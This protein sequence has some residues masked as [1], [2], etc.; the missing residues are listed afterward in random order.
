MHCTSVP[1]V[2]TEVWTVDTKVEILFESCEALCGGKTQIS[3]P[4]FK[5]FSLKSTADPDHFEV[6]VSVPV[7][8]LD[9]QLQ[10]V[11]ESFHTT[12]APTRY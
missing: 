11:I 6:T 10:L 2:T 4:Y 8:I 5:I 3:S 12:I 7:T 9:P 1:H